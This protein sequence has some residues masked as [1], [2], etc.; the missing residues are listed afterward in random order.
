MTFSL[1]ACG[2]LNEGDKFYSTKWI[3]IKDPK[4]VLVVAVADD[5]YYKSTQDPKDGGIAGVRVSW[6]S[7]SVKQIYTKKEFES[8]VAN[9]RLAAAIEEGQKSELMAAEQR[10]KEERAFKVKYGADHELAKKYKETFDY[11][12][13]PSEITELKN[14]GVVASK[15]IE[16]LKAKQLTYENI[17]GSGF[18]G[19][20]LFVKDNKIAEDKR[21]SITR[22]V[23]LREN[24]QEAER[25]RIQR[26]R[27]EAQRIE[28]KMQEDYEKE[29]PYEAIISCTYGEGVQNL[30][31]CFTAGHNRVKTELE[32]SNGSEY[33][34]Y[35]FSEVMSAGAST[36][37]GK[38]IVRLN[39]KFKIS[40]QNASQHL[41]LNVVIREVKTKKIIFQKSASQF[42][43]IKVGS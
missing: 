5:R 7:G 36:P 21:I 1:S 18:V 42:N 9:A 13:T 16:I 27:L 8:V 2:S 4:F 35:Q 24:E 15:N 17:Y 14:Y 39:S 28:K 11:L 32:I 12:P 6:N 33:R 3:S 31:A 43:V 38:L 41:L 26:Q 34:M 20:S 19:F 25:K 29:N 22:A 23:A 30:I 40:A 10:D 37:D